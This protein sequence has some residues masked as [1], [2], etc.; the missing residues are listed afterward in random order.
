MM[1]ILQ[2]TESDFNN[3][4]TNKLMIIKYRARSQV[5]D[6]KKLCSVTRSTY[7]TI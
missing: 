4:Y 2:L 7:N 3:Y 1:H 5:S 6:L